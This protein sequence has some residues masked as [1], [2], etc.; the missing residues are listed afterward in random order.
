MLDIKEVMKPI[1]DKNKYGKL[2]KTGE[3]KEYV[4]DP[5]K[6]LIARSLFTSRGVSY[7]DQVFDGDLNGFVKFIKLFSGIKP[8]EI[9]L[10]V[11]KALKDKQQRRA[12]E[13]LLIKMGYL[14]KYESTYEPKQ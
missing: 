14:R 12:M 3:R 11:T 4:A 2:V 10:E 9:D 1:Y 5:N 8:T 13:D 6:L 7:L